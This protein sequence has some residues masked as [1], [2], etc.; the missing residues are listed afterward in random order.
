MLEKASL[1]MNGGDTFGDDIR[2]FTLNCWGLRGISAKRKE[3]MEA[4]GAYLSRGEY[5]I[6]LLQEVWTHE[7]FERIRNAVV[8]ALPHAH[9][10]DNGIIGSGT[11]VFTRV[12]INDATFHEF[13]MN[14]YP[15]KI[16]HG[17]WFGGKGLGVCQIEFKG[18]D[19]H[20]YTSHYHAEYD[21]THD[22]YLGHR[23]VHAI[24][25]AQ[26]IKLASSSADLTIYAG[27]FNT[28][29]TDVPY[30]LVRKITPLIDAWEAAHGSTSGG[31]TCD[32]PTNSFANQALL[33]EYPEGKRIDY[34]MYQSG[35][36]MK[37]TTVQCSLPLPNKIAGKEFS[38]SD[39]EAVCATIRLE[40]QRES[41]QS[42]PDFRRFHS[43]QNRGECIP[44]VQ[45]ALEILDNAETHVA[46]DCWQYCSVSA[47]LFFFLILSFL[48]IILIDESYHA[49]IEISLFLP[50]F[51]ITICCIFFALMGTVFNRREKNALKAA[52][53]SLMLICKQDLKIDENVLT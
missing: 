1:A 34:I 42:C 27:D 6:V 29:P 32:V 18:F 28:E 46:M 51:L 7:D 24:E 30:K 14:G 20:V 48:P 39:H 15:H 50:R 12:Q 8:D 38:Y 49:A 47:F 10:F 23:V 43:R 13:T 45:S 40:R 37:A 2:V 31:E 5:D 3:R 53:N 22:V 41:Y 36:N 35:P 26:W 44:V 19:I 16:W 17:D 33:R 25:S 52:K 9:F 11:C 21:R 4:I